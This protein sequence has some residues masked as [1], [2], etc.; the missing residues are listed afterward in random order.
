MNIF[1]I[2]SRK[3]LRFPST[4]GDLTAEQL[5]DLP[6]IDGKR[7]NLDA[8]AREIATALKSVTEES[9]V[10]TKPDPRAGELL[11]KLE[12]VKH[13]IEVKILEKE[14]AEKAAANKIKRQKILEAL[15]ERDNADLKSKSKDELLKE[16]E[17]LDG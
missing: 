2:A 9:F 11:T 5:W 14:A 15:A 7:A 4:V 6:L 13:V 8:T 3:K 12:I 10:V 16:L 1:E 17:A